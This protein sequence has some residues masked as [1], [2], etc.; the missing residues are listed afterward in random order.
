MD[1]DSSFLCN[2]PFAIEA[3]DR[4]SETPRELNIRFLACTSN[5]LGFLIRQAAFFSPLLRRAYPSPPVCC[6]FSAMASPSEKQHDNAKSYDS[7][8]LSG[9]P[10]EVLKRCVCLFAVERNT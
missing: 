3:V 4:N 8:S 9:H 2:L 1:Y 10:R 6:T 7:E 5:E